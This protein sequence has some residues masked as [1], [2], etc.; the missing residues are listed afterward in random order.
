MVCHFVCKGQRLCPVSTRGLLKVLQVVD[1]C[2]LLSQG[3]TSFTRIWTIA[4]WRLTAARSQDR[5]HP[6]HSYARP[7]RQLPTTTISICTTTNTCTNTTASMGWGSP[8][9]SCPPSPASGEWSRHRHRHHRRHLH[10]HSHHHNSCSL[11]HHLVYNLTVTVSRE[12]L[13]LFDLW[14]VLSL[15]LFYLSFGLLKNKTCLLHLYFS[16]TRFQSRPLSQACI[17]PGW[18]GPLPQF[19]WCPSNNSSQNKQKKKKDFF[20]WATFPKLLCKE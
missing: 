1:T 16:L 3:K 18:V 7:L 8:P 5:C 15:C 13:R 12:Y 6:R 2:G 11:C 20:I 10:N 4:Y 9:L 17:D 19:H 14:Q